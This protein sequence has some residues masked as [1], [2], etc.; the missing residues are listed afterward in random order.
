MKIVNDDLY[1]IEGILDQMK[2]P[3]P[4]PMGMKAFEEW[5]DRIISGALLPGGE[6]NPKVF[7]ED[8]KFALASML[9][10]LG[11]TE[12]HK[13]D[14]YFIHALRKGAVNQIAH[15]VIMNTKAKQ[16][17]RIEAE[18]ALKGKDEIKQG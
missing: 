1:P 11:P 9:M 8:Q 10:H 12:S 18:E 13:P 2:E 3:R 16:K 5:S 17:A 4:L 14:I 6:D 15:A 7:I